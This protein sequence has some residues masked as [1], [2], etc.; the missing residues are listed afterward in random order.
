MPIPAR[1]VLGAPGERTVEVTEVAG[2][3]TRATGSRRDHARA[4]DLVTAHGLEQTV[5]GVRHVAVLAL[6]SAR[7]GLVVRVLGRGG[8]D[9]EA[10]VALGAG[11]VRTHARRELVVGPLG[12][13]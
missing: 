10:L 3:G 13:R 9:G 7:S 5:C 12:A 2:I 6:A 11:A 1:E 4:A 8:L